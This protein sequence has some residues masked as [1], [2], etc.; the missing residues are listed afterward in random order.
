ML[1]TMVDDSTKAV[2]KLSDKIFIGR[3][4]NGNENDN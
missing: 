4:L 2:N 3:I 1:A